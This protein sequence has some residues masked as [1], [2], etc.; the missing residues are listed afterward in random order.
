ML[1]SLKLQYPSNVFLIR[2]NHE[3]AG[4]NCHF[5]FLNECMYRLGRDEGARVYTEMNAVFAELPMAA[6]SC[7]Y[8]NLQQA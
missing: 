2:G 3:D 1:L 6:V 7:T 5:G 4:I 8:I